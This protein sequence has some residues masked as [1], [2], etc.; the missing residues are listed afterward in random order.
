MFRGELV[1]LVGKQ[2]ARIAAQDVRLVTSD[3]QPANFH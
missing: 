2:A 3:G 1:V